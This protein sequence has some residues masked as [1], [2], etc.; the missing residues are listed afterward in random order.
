MSTLLSDP[1][2]ALHHA[3]LH[4]LWKQCASLT[5]LSG[6]EKNQRWEDEEE[7]EDEKRED[8]EILRT[9]RKRRHSSMKEVSLSEG[10]V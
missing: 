6:C 10:T 3:D 9:E 8:R 1:S 5:A 7:E 2:T 4:S